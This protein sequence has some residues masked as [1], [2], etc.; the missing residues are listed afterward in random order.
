MSGSL[1]QRDRGSQQEDRVGSPFST[2]VFA[3]KT[4]WCCNL[5]YVSSFAVSDRRCGGRTR[6]QDM[7]ERR[8]RASR[9]ASILDSRG[10]CAARSTPSIA[11]FLLER[12]HIRESP[13]AGASIVALVDGTSYR[14]ARQSYNGQLGLS[15]SSYVAWRTLSRIPHREVLRATC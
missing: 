11:S 1:A 7:T 13:L 3:A 8:H 6:S 14:L 9:L 2:N 4:T 5:S 12:D 15:P 10:M